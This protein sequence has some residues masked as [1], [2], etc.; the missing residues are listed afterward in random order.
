MQA[1]THIKRRLLLFDLNQN[2]NILTHFGKT[3]SMKFY[4]NPFSYLGVIT[5]EQTNDQ[6][7]EANRHIFSTIH[8]ERNKMRLWHIP[9]NMPE[10]AKRKHGEDREKEH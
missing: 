6:R 1:E 4:E 8:W 3:P 10:R 2:W 5:C 7:G 9:H